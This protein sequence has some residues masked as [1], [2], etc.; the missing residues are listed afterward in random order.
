[1]NTYIIVWI[2]DKWYL[3][4][5]KAALRMV[6]EQDMVILTKTKHVSVDHSVLE[7]L[8]SHRLPYILAH[9][10]LQTLH[11]INQ[12]CSSIFAPEEADDN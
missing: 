3:C 11:I 4:T 5:V 8:Y 10:Q 7:N 6:K 2:I 12:V 9:I 1:M